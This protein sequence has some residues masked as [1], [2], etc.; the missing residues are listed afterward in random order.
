MVKWSVLSSYIINGLLKTPPAAQDIESVEAQYSDDLLLISAQFALIRLSYHTAEAAQFVFNGDGVTKVI[1][2]PNNRVDAFTKSSLVTYN[3]GK[4]IKHIPPVEFSVNSVLS[5]TNTFYQYYEMP[6]GVLHLDFVP[7]QGSKVTLDYFKI[8]DAPKDDNSELMF[9]DWMILPFCYL[10]AASAIEPYGVQASS[11]RQ[12]N[13]KNDSGTPEH[14]PLHKQTKHFQD[15]AQMILNMYGSQDRD[16]FFN[17][18][19]R[20]RSK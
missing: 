14:N 15:Q 9:P 8:W 12:W 19:A 17:P 6:S 3:D 20:T 5:S 10:V 2:L 11:I 1:P 7:I 4:Q 18:D 13:R 16:T